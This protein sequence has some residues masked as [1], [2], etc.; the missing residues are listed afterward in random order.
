MLSRFLLYGFVVAAGVMR[1]AADAPA[2]PNIVFFLVDDMGWQ[3]TSVPF[4]YDE[5]GQPVVTPLNRRYRTPAMEQLAATG[6]KFT[7]AYA[8]PVCT[9]SRICWMIGKNSVRHHVTNW[10]HPKGIETTQN[11]VAS[12]RSP[13]DWRRAGL[14]EDAVT[15][16]A[17]LQ[18]AGYRTIH[19]GKAHFGATEH[20]RNPLNV[21][22]DV[23]IAGSEIGHPGSFSGDYG[24]KSNRPVRGLEAYHHSGIHLT[25]STTIEV[26]KAIGRAVHEKRPFFAYVAHY[27]VHSPFE[28]DPR[29]AA[30]YP[31]LSGGLL[32]YATLLE[33]M[34][35][36][37][38][39]IL[40][41]LRALGVAENTIVVFMSDNGG[42]APEPDVNDSNAPLR[43]KKGSK[44]EG[45][46]RVPLIAGWAAP[47]EKNPHQ[48]RLPISPGTRKDDI[49]AIFDIFP[50]FAGIAGI[51]APGDI[52]GHDLSPYLQ[53]KP[54]VHR[55]QE[56][57][58][59]FPHD[60]RSQY[61]TIF[62]QGPWKL[63][64]NH[65]PRGF[66]LYH[67]GRDISESE[68][69]A[70]AEPDRVREMVGRALEVFN[71]AGGQWPVF[72]EGGAE[73]PLTAP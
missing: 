52:D 44:Y 4:L 53:G 35:K 58:I 21:G 60:H 43:H 10:T 14:Q 73:D 28:I 13:T 36:S 6:M 15:L 71:E 42:D 67:L 39:D 27:A 1:L 26:K 31:D 69:L 59:H 51:E 70:A 47:D 57:L 23:N 11:N 12:H 61:F 68:N 19:A 48:Q 65:A 49:V 37:L 16:P 5:Q 25:E 46:V 7:N 45:G 20:A 24:Q 40:S 33:G 38:G 66:E 3:D 56:L 54:G 29:F 41:H 17:L 50:T 72:A 62:R 8:M 22:F 64:H 34:D 2:P 30:N 55:P 63:I 9:P 18:A 32:G